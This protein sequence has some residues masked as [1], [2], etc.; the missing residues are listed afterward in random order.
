[1][2]HPATFEM[3]VHLL[4]KHGA[5]LK[6]YSNRYLFEEGVLSN[7]KRAKRIVHND[8][9]VYFVKTGKVVAVWDTMGEIGTVYFEEYM[10]E[11]LCAKLLASASPFSMAA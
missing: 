10:S 1:M 8:G 6:R 3:P 5:S 11:K 4:P 9:K 2:E 7:V